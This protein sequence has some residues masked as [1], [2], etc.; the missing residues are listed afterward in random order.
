[1]ATCNKDNSNTHFI[2]PRKT[3]A[4]I[5]GLRFSIHIKLK[6]RQKYSIMIEKRGYFW[7]KIINGRRYKEGSALR[8]SLEL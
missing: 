7:E 6:N 3:D 8:K 4:R 2:K 5:P 1:M